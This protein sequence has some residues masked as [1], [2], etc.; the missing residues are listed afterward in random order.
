MD[1][2]LQHPPEEIPNLINEI[3]NGYDVVYGKPY[4]DKKYT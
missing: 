3:N 4:K 1:D 2:D